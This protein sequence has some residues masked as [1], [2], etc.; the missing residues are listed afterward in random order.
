MTAM[1]PLPKRQPPRLTPNLRPPEFPLDEETSWDGVVASAADT[2]TDDAVGCEISGSRLNGVQFTGAEHPRLRLLDVVLDDCEFSGAILSEA[3]FVRVEFNQ[4][5]MSGLVVSGLTARDVR[6]S[7][8]K[9]D[10]LNFRTAKLDRC[11]WNDCLLSEADFYAS[12]IST[13]S[14]H[15]CDLS[16]A[17]FSRAACDRVSLHG[18]TLDRIRG[19]NSLGGCTIGTD[20]V[21]TLAPSLL[22]A[23]GIRV[24]DDPDRSTR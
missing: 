5:R 14:F 12:K 8:C 11:E 9:L 6:W 18:S 7:G 22:A 1:G 17:E 20:Q 13:S 23:V 16:R 10:G 15:G 21:T 24:D 3:T 4:C 2:I 19:A